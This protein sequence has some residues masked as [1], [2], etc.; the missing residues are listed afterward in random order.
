M[1]AEFSAW[2]RESGL[3]P[4]SGDVRPH[5]SAWRLVVLRSSL[6]ALGAVPP[7]AGGMNG[8]RP[9]GTLGHQL[10]GYRWPARFCGPSQ[11][12]PGTK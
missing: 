9:V 3:N 4:R 11:P 8:L 1:V 2:T 6:R 5:A 12:R 7:R 10:T